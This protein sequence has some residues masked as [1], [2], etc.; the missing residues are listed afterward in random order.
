MFA[1]GL[2]SSSLRLSVLILVLTDL[3]R[4]SVQTGEEIYH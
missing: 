1:A 2:S 3:I 4:A